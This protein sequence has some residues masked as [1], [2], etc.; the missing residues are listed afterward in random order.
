MITSPHEVLKTY[1]GY[2]SFRPSQQDIIEAVLE[3][4]DAFTLLPTGGGKSICYQIPGLLREG[5]TLVISPLLSLMRDQ[6]TQLQKRNIKALYIPGG[7]HYRELDTLL[8]NCIYGNYKFLYLSPERLQSELVLERIKQMNIS[9]IAV[10]EAHCISQWGHDFRPAYR[11]ISQFRENLPDVNCIA[12]TATATR[13]VQKDII[14]QLQLQ[15]PAVFKNSFERKNLAYR[16]LWEEDKRNRLVQGFKRASGSGIV[17]VRSRKT[18]MDYASFLQQSG[19]SAHFYHGGLS[20]GERQQ[21][22]EAWSA[23]Q[24]QVM[25][26][27]SAFG[28][29]IDKADV[30]TVVHVELPESM[31]SYFQEAGRAGRNGKPS[32]SLI[33]ANASDESRL[34]NQFLKVLPSVSYVKKVYKKLNSFFQIPYGGGEQE[35]FRFDF[36]SFCHTYNFNTLITYNALQ[37]LDRNSII[38]LS[39]EF[40]RKATLQLKVSPVQLT[41]YLIQNPALDNIVKGILRTYAGIYDQPLAIDHALLSKKT[42]TPL[43][44]VHEALLQLEKDDLAIYE[45]TQFDTAITFLVQREDELSINPIA[46]AI[47]AQNMRKLE[48]VQSI[49][50][51]VNNRETCRSIQ[52]LAYFEE[53][54]QEPCGICDVCMASKK[55]KNKQSSTGLRDRILLALQEKEHS[56]RELSELIKVE[57]E[58]ELTQALKSLL[59]SKQIKLTPTNRYTLL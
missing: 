12:L 3:G 40:Y 38:I 57:D 31:E 1:W 25:V 23:N 42:G 2:D 13:Q 7:I 59:L 32:Q 56:S 55:D 45:H 53:T 43:P 35:T 39:Q 14:E 49:L 29:G 24:T 54:Q 30:S 9:L 47:K 11:N 33:L 48:Q 26:A 58:K 34:S 15:D 22:F 46:P 37:L 5:L 8:D 17:Y 52:L 21:R 27:T 10:D 6:V 50:T 16:V 44:R 28:M 18:A 19:I 4:R 41:Y 51:Y 36:S 20:T